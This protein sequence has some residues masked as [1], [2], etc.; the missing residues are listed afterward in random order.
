M[1][2]NAAVGSAIE[3]SRYL[4]SLVQQGAVPVAVI[5]LLANFVM[6]YLLYRCGQGR[7]QD[8]DDYAQHLREQVDRIQTGN[9]LLAE[10]AKMSRLF[11]D[12][13]SPR[14]SAAQ[15]RRTERAEDE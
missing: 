4:E 3:V 13:A 9:N 2:P 6:S 12:R 14:T 15:R 8:K 5:S 1:D 7:L 10:F 11:E